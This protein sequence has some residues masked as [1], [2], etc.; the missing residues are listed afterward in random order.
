[1]VAVT[2]T[3]EFGSKAAADDYRK[4]YPELIC[5]DDD[6]RLKTVRFSSDAPESVLEAAE[7]D[8]MATHSEGETGVGQMA[9]EQNELEAIDWTEEG[10]NVPKARSVKALVHSHN[11]SEPFVRVFEPDL[12]VDEHHEKIR[13]LERE[14]GGEQMDVHEQS[15]RIAERRG[16]AAS[17]A[18]AEQCSHA[19]GHCEHGDPEAC[20]FL[21][22]VCGFDDEDVEAILGA[23]EDGDLPGRIHGAR[24]QLWRRYQIGIANAKE[25]AAAINE[26]NQQYGQDLVEFEQLGDRTINRDDIDWKTTT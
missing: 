3:V 25:A 24:S 13:Q 2:T 23:D 4:E 12:N 26:I 1:M 6:A 9:L 5:S 7:T 15:E 18:S 14:T 19:R 8:A 16:R 17:K 11:I 10:A 22:T 20:E 21:K